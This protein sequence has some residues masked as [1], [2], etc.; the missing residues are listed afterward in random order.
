VAKSC[1]D[2]GQAYWVCTLI[3]ESE[4]LQCEAAEMTYESLC[5]QLPQLNIGLVHG[6]MKAAQKEAAIAAFKQGDTHILVATT[7]I[8]VGVDVPNA[9]IMIL[10]NPERLGLAQIHQLRGRVG[11][12]ARESFCILLVKNG[13]GELARTRLE[14][15]RSTQ[16]GFT[17]AERD[18]EIRGAGEVL[19][20]RQTGEMSFRI[21]DLM[22][23]QK[24]FP[25]VEKL[26]KLMQRPE[27]A[28]TRAE[29]LRNWIGERQDYTDV[30]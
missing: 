27:Y 22:R 21:A 10:E 19:G 29:L 2:G 3:E 6:R 30:G 28:Q 11:R 16:D 23:D 24:W 17:I 1:A 15:I 26:A 8:E 12:G 14:I 5:Q 9:S 20:T 13:L 18:L 7:V 4:A 25:Q